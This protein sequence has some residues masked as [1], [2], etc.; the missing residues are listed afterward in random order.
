MKEQFTNLHVSKQEYIFSSDS[1]M[2]TQ[3]YMS[4]PICPSHVFQQ[5]GYRLQIFVLV[6]SWGGGVLPEKLGRGVRPAS[7]IPYP[8]Y[9]QN[10]QFSLPPDQKFD[11]LF[12]T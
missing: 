5:Q 6:H 2:N 4:G 7:Q 8:I 12:M 9:D 10:L 11:T 3:M 1:F